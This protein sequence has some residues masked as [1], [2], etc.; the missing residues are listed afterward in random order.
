MEVI[1]LGADGSWPRVGGAASGYLIRHDGFSIWVDLGTG[2]MANLQEHVGLYDV[3]AVLVSHIHADHL[4]DL[5]TYFYSRNY[6]PLE[7]PPSIPLIMPPGATDHVLNM[8]SGSG[9]H[10]IVNRFDIREIEPGTDLD[11]GPFEIHTAP[12]AHPV[13]TLGMRFEAGGATVAYSADTGPCAD[14]VGVARDVDLLLA[15]ATWLED[16]KHRPPGIH[17]TAKEAGEH[18]EEAG[19]GE[20]I[21]VHINPLSDR[22][23]AREEAASTFS[24]PLDLGAAGMKRVVG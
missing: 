10:D 2:T 15:E 11:L 23:R 6:G 21:L 12:M 20:L 4:V 9:G 17:L 1:V 19:A 22:E 8:L 7:P 5:F 3:G 13:P 18:A 16:G 14:L 24:G